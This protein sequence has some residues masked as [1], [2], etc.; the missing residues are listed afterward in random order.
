MML[1]PMLN[2]IQIWT[3]KNRAHTCKLNH[4]IN[5][6]KRLFPNQLFIEIES[7]SCALTYGQDLLILLGLFHFRCHA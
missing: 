2:R 4:R 6:Q 5:S 7:G 3:I 1:M